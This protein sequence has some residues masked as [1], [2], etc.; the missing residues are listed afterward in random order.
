MPVRARALTTDTLTT[1]TLTTDKTAVTD[2]IELRFE[3]RERSRLRACLA[4]GEEIGI[5]L[6]VG[7]ILSHGNRLVLDDGRV[8]A[9]EA[10]LEALLQVTAEDL[11][12]LARIAAQMP[13]S[14]A[15]RVSLVTERNLD[16]VTVANAELIHTS[17]FHDPLADEQVS[18][19]LARA[20]GTV[21]VAEIARRSGLGPRTVSAVARLIRAGEVRLERHEHIG[22]GARVC[23]TEISQERKAA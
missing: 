10:A 9:V 5:D 18:A 12:T 4:S 7:T 21:I 6:A 8:V 3:Q 23:A 20:T 22:M 19:V 11:A 2:I 14:V 17:R 16:A 13:R 15:D 1:D